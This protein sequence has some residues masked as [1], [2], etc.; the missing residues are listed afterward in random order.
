MISVQSPRPLIIAWRW[1]CANLE[2]WLKYILV[3]NEV[4]LRT[5]SWVS[6]GDTRCSC[7]FSQEAV[8]SCDRMF[9]ADCR[10]ASRLVTKLLLLACKELSFSLYAQALHQSRNCRHPWLRKNISR[11]CPLSSRGP[12]EK[13]KRKK[14]THC[15]YP[16]RNP[17]PSQT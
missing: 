8:N 13:R 4:T 14:N 11:V 7:C 9:N 3:M 15:I 1:I 16:R 2:T 12:D 6:V 17:T 5:S 10:I